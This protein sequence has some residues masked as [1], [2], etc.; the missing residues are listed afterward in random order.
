MGKSD[1]ATIK[2]KWFGYTHIFSGFN[3]ILS[4]F[5]FLLSV[6]LVYVFK[7]TAVGE[8]IPWISLFMLST[9]AIMFAGGISFFNTKHDIEYKT[10][11]FLW[12]FTMF[13]FFT[14]GL[15]FNNT[16]AIWEAL[17]GKK[18]DFIR[19]PKFSLSDQKESNKWSGFS[20]IRKGFE[21]QIIIES[22]L[23]IYFILGIFLGFYYK[24]YHL[25]P[26]HLMLVIGYSMIVYYSIKH[27]IIEK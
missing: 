26:L 20:Y 9:F 25:I 17:T 12:R 19:T 15:S 6:P 11:T 21:T 5:L 8:L 18:S 24:F 1:N 3:Y 4:F 14:M 22:L 2:Q 13:L 7:F 16:V 27:A 10:I 23:L